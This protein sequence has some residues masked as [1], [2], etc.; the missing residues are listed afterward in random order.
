M[1]VLSGKEFNEKYKDVRFVK[2]ASSKWKYEPTDKYFNKF[3]DKQKYPYG[4]NYFCEFDK[5]PFWLVYGITMHYKEN[6]YVYIYDV[7]VPDDALVCVDYDL[8]VPYNTFKTDK[9]ELKNKQKIEDLQVWNDYDFCL[10]AVAQE[11]YALQYV[12]LTMP[13]MVK[14]CL[15]A[16]KHDC[17][18]FKYYKRSNM[19]YRSLITKH[20]IQYLKSEIPELCLAIL[21]Q[22][23]LGLEY[24]TEQTK[25]LCL[26][27]VKQN[28]R[29][30]EFIDTKKFKTEP[31]LNW[32]FELC[33]IGVKQ[34]G[35]ALKFIKENECL[36]KICMTMKSKDWITELCLEAVKQYGYGLKYV[37]NYFNY[38]FN[39]S[40]LYTMQLAAVNQYAYAI[41]LIDNPSEEL[42]LAAVA[43][44]GS[45]LQYIKKQTTKIC[46]IAMKQSPC[47]YNYVNAEMRQRVGH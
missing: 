18:K 12:K 34:D 46:L 7:V 27:A 43:I 47:A 24:V 23:G 44:D 20:S 15:E 35:F 2:L 42:C 45:A 25:E 11:A 5:F 37:N 13:E 36:N 10:Q 8:I 22:D 31:E 39:K 41:T 33:L 6:E 30:L 17:D 29:A 26:T 4:G 16:V 38:C 32:L 1:T 19:P 28:G 40:E 21:G 3:D 14:I 9:F